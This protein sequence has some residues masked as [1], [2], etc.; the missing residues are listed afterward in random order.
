MHQSEFWGALVT[1]TGGIITVA[2]VA[3][4]FSR[5]SQAPAVIQAGGSAFGNSLAVAESPVTGAKYRIDL[6]YPH[7][8]GGMDLPTLQ[9]PGFY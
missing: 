1:I 5:N 3:T 9:T 8:A 2:I 6:S 7:S 4:I